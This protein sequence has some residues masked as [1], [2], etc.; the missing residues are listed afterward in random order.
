[1]VIALGV[2][3]STCRAILPPQNSHLLAAGIG[4]IG[5][6]LPMAMISRHMQ[7]SGLKI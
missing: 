4:E 1:M 6:C 5:I 3:L 2:E 7:R